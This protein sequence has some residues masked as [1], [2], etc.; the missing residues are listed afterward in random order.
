MT[1]TRKLSAFGHLKKIVLIYIQSVLLW[2]ED[3]NRNI[4]YLHEVTVIS[5]IKMQLEILRSF[6]NQEIYFLHDEKHFQ[7]LL[8]ITLWD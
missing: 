7:E 5:S 2:L 1:I 8:E 3:R 6:G 4:S